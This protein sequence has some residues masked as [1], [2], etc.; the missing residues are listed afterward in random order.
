MPRTDVTFNS[1][2]AATDV[3]VL[4]DQAVV[5]DRGE[6]VVVRSPASPN[7]HWGNFLLSRVPPRA[8]ARE[9]WEAAFEREFADQPRS[10]HRAFAW[11]GEGGEE[12]AA[13]EFGAAGYDLDPCA[14]LV[15]RPE[16]LVAHPRANAEVEIRALDPAP[17]ADEALWHAT[18]ELQVA[19]RGEGHPEADYREFLADR[20]AERRRRFLAGDGAWFVATMPGGEV[21][22]A[23]GIV[24]TQGR[25]RYQAVDTAEAFRRRGIA[26]RLVHD[27]GAHAVRELGARH[28]VIG[29]ETDYHALPLYESLGFVVRERSLAVCWW[30]T[31]PNAAEHPDAER[32]LA[33]P[34]VR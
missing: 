29:A 6:Y 30:P 20:T 32:L 28:L 7:H 19:G 33:R 10:R 17:G 9:A 22:A 2:L 11:E 25:A 1:L 14:A 31:A 24:V 13:A 27:A 12:V 4:S 18:A 26:R 15:A 3:D 16:E 8:G 21:V 5:V 34:G 23:C